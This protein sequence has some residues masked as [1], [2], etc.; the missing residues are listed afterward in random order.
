M[1]YKWVYQERCNT[2]CTQRRYNEHWHSHGARVGG[3]AGP[4]SILAGVSCGIC[5]NPLRNFCFWGRGLIY[6]DMTASRIHWW[7]F[8]A[9]RLPS[10]EN[11][12]MCPP[13]FYSVTTATK[14]G[15]LIF[16]NCSKNQKTSDSNTGLFL[17]C[18][19][20]TRG[21]GYQENP[22]AKQSDNATSSRWNSYKMQ[23]HANSIIPR[24]TLVTRRDGLALTQNANQMPGWYQYRLILDNS[25]ASNVYPQPSSFADFSLGEFCNANNGVMV[26]L[27]WSKP[28]LPWQ[29]FFWRLEARQLFLLHQMTS[30]KISPFSRVHY[31]SNQL[32]KM[33]LMIS[34]TALNT[35]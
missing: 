35:N 31:W 20:Q 4:Y 5:A 24:S 32:I 29:G 30:R 23:L 22:W 19:I 6:M 3:G 27:V 15:V 11:G 7:P 28:N 33:P 9:C 34:W 8:F 17:H 14:I 2:R 13:Q 25:G 1:Q 26:S 16:R 21:I 10:L 18:F 12:V